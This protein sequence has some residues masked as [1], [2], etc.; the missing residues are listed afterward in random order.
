[1]R[2]ADAAALARID[3]LLAEIRSEPRL[4]ERRTGV[5]YFK[6]QAF[7][8]FHEDPTGIYGDLKRN[9]DWSRF[10]VNTMTE[11]KRLL[12]SIATAL[13]EGR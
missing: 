3:R 4:K 9:G 5:F 8:H 13:A 12:Q 2:H 6:G 10:A 1:V 7:L 11:Q